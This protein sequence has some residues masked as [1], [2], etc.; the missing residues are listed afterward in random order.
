LKSDDTTDRLI[1]ISN[2]KVD[3]RKEIIQKEET[4]SKVVINTWYWIGLTRPFHLSLSSTQNVKSNQGKIKIIV[5]PL[6]SQNL[7]GEFQS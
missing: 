3:N 2:Q 5:L 7:R 6:S 1:R 4:A